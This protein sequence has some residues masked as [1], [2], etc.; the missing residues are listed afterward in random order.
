MSQP[1]DAQ[2]ETSRVSRLPRPAY[3]T[4]TTLTVLGLTLSIYQ[5]FG[6]TVGDFVILDVGYFF[7]LI[8]LFLPGAFLTLPASR[9]AKKR[10][11]V[12]WYDIVLAVLAFIIPVWFFVETWEAPVVGMIPPPLLYMI[13]SI[14][15]ILLTIESG[16]R[17]AGNVY[18][19]VCLV[20]GLYPLFAGYMPGPLFGFGFNFPKTVG[21]VVFGSQGI[22]GI[23]SHVMGNILMGFLVFAGFMIATGAGRFFLN[24]ALFFAGRFRGGPAKVSVVS[25]MLFGTLSG[26]AVSNIVADG[27]ITIPAMKRCGFS[28]DYSGAIEAVASTG[29]HIVPPVMGGVAFI[30]CVFLAVDYAVVMVAALIPALLYYFALLMGVDA[31]SA[32]VGLKGLPKSDIPSIRQTLK[33]GWPFIAVIA[34]L[35]WGLV[36][37][38]MGMRAPFYATALMIL[39]ALINKETRLT[40]KSFF[41]AV[42]ESG[43]LIS[44]TYAIMLPMG[45]IINGLISTGVTSSMTSSMIALGGSNVVLILIIGFVACYVMGMAG[46]VSPAYIF[47]AVSMAPAAVQVAGLSKLAVHFFIVYYTMLAPITLPVAGGAFVAAAIAGAS[48]IKTGWTCMRLAMVT[49]FIPFWF[50]FEPALLLQGNLTPLLWELPLAIIGTMLIAGGSEGYIWR[51]GEIKAIWQRVVLVAGGVLIAFPEITSSLVGLLLT[52]LI[53][54]LAY[55]KRKRRRPALA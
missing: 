36:Y 11:G 13:P 37:L 1:Q 31:Y 20:F 25:S 30:M 8:G 32:R 48:P 47:L 55:Y 33:N 44:Q 3:Y 51:I 21:L 39:L 45:F 18:V 53:I 9:K 42:T 19:A 17:I 46:L 34:F 5:M 16:R 35:T 4:V 52:V 7:L 26:S 49:Y 6:L 23:P 41:K 40:P 29:G 14:I 38:R 54:A 12:P 10:R 28:P 24:I 22:L 43:Q 15:L 50:A 2:A 27:G